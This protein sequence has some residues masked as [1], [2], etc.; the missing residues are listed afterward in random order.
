MRSFERPHSAPTE[1]PYGARTPGMEATACALA[2]RRVHLA[3]VGRGKGP[4][5]S[6]FTST[7][8]RSLV[9]SDQA[10][11]GHPWVGG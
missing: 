7:S 8:E 9:R 5:V 2:H 10:P 1:P 6:R 3:I 4:K 11:S